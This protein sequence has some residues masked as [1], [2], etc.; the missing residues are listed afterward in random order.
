VGSI[1]GSGGGRDGNIVK[2]ITESYDDFENKYIVCS[3]FEG[4]NMRRF[5]HRCRGVDRRFY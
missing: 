1:G 5:I 4:M 3:P 2:Y